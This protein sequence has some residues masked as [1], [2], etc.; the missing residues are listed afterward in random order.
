MNTELPTINDFPSMMEFRS[1]LMR[2][3]QI[4]SQILAVDKD[5]DAILKDTLTLIDEKIAEYQNDHKEQ[6]V[7][8]VKNNL[9]LISDYMEGID[10][11]PQITS[12][13]GTD[14]WKQTEQIL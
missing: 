11:L 13:Y 2:I 3:K 9:K 6:I 7:E 10:Y 12:V 14:L 1:E 5:A 8:D 4:R